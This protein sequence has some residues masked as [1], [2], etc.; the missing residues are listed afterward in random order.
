MSFEYPTQQPIQ[1]EKKMSAEQEENVDRRLEA[2]FKKVSDVLE[3]AEAAEQFIAKTSEKFRNNIENADKKDCL[4]L[5]EVKAKVESLT[6]QEGLVVGRICKDDRGVY[7]YE[8]SA[9]DESGD[10]YV[11][12]YKRVGEYK[13]SQAANTLIEVVYYMGSLEDDIC[14]GGNILANYDEESHEWVNVD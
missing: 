1:E 3:E 8:V 5:A 9:M 2:G 4:S 7:L 6:K 13:E 14:C 11:Y 10:A 12:A